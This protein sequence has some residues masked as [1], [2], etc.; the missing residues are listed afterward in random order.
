MTDIERIMSPEAA[1]RLTDR[2]KERAAELWADLLRAY[3]NG[4]HTALGYSSWGAYYEAE[5]G[6]DRSRGYQLLQAAQVRAIL[7]STN[8][9]S[10]QTEGVAR[11]LAPLRDDP[12]ALREAWSEAVEQHGPSPTAAEVHDIVQDRLRPE[13]EPEPEPGLSKEVAE[14]VQTAKDDAS[15]DLAYLR[16]RAPLRELQALTVGQP[17][18][19]EQVGATTGPERE[20]FLT[21]LESVAPALERALRAVRRGRDGRLERV[22]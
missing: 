7:E 13:P 6:Q 8:V 16:A 22:K 11:Q 10:P 12:P 15:R 21:M 3:E 1:R 9:D 4:A 5:F 17:Q 18:W 20:Q 19:P 14:L 2:I